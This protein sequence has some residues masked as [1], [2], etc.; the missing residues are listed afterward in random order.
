M[1][2]IRTRIPR[3]IKIIPYVGNE[4]FEVDPELDASGRFSVGIGAAVT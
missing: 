1:I 3:I 4:E 2:V